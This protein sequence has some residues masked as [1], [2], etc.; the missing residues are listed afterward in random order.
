MTLNAYEGFDV[1]Q[2]SIKVT[3]AG[4]GLSQAINVDPVEYHVGDV[5]HVVLETVV[6]RISY[7]TIKDTEVL[8]RV[9]TLRAGSGTI[10]DES[11]ARGVLAAQEIAIERAKGVV[12]LDL[13]GNGDGA[14]PKPARRARKPKT[15]A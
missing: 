12:R 2:A 9:H 15:D 5:V 11:Y 1:V 7:E 4:D 6:S 3:N 10:V 13:D 8:K 14:A